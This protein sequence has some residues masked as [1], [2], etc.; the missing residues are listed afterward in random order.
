VARDA[1][2]FFPTQAS[3][4]A[5]GAIVINAANLRPGLTP[6]DRIKPPKNFSETPADADD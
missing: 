6:H 3:L 1:R 2:T 5:S 4:P